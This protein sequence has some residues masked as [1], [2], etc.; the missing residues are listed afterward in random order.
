[1]V[2]QRLKTLREIMRKENIDYYLITNQDPH[3]SEYT[4]EFFHYRTLFSGFT[5]SNG[6]LLVGLE[7]AYL[8]T[9]GRYFIQAE[10]ELAGTGIFLMRMGERN[11]PT[12]G[13]FLAERSC[14]IT[15][16]FDG[17]TVFGKYA[18]NLREVFEKENQKR[19]NNY[20]LIFS[21]D[22]NLPAEVINSLEPGSISSF[23]AGRW[24]V[25]NRNLRGQ[26]TKDK[27]N[28]VR[29]YLKKH[30]ADFYLSAALDKNMWLLN[31]RGCDIKRNPV[32]YSYLYIGLDRV[33]VFCYEDALGEKEKEYLKQQHIEYIKYEDFTQ[34]LILLS[35]GRT[36]VVTREDINC[37]TEAMIEKHAKKVMDSDCGIS[38]AKACKTKQEIKNMRKIFE[39]DSACVCKFLY[40]L[41]VQDV[42]KIS[43]YEAALKM[44]E[45]R[46]SQKECFDLSFDTIAAYGPNAAMMHY[47]ATKNESSMLK[48]QGMFLLDSGGQYYGGTTDVTRTVALGKVSEKMQKDF[49]LALKGM[50]SLSKAVFMKGT[51]GE[52]LD[53]LAREPLWRNHSDYKCGTGHGIGY[54]LS[55]HETPPGIRPLRGNNPATEAFLPG[56]VVS[57]EPGVYKE[58]RYGIRI[59]NIL[60][61]KELFSNEDGDFYGFETL[62]LVPIDHRLI[63]ERLLMEEEKEWLYEY[64]QNVYKRISPY[65]NEAEQEWLKT[66]TA[67]ERQNR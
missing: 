2:L 59:E 28:S 42:G 17:M 48:P 44:D 4:S 26:E 5:G 41:S 61:C 25:L 45:I 8:W 47:E 35:E 20:E 36:A 1:M 13:G 64:H 55:V 21:Q 10:K 40:W 62:T 31:M 34:N 65:L 43:E 11:V 66:E 18:G 63:D 58:N 6:T 14:D 51:K 37:L 56:M 24:F 57:N 39:L 23:R 22:R 46:L 33:L 50:I 12:I 67:F 54:M 16:G 29:E 19:G 3:H 49:T 30:H 53:I 32:G 60:L 38:L 7:D 52:C 27:I 9:D 15:L